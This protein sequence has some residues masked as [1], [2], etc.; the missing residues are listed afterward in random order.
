MAANYG[1]AQ[2]AES[3]RDFIHKLKLCLK[4]LRESVV[5]LELVERMELGDAGAARRS[6]EEADSLAAVLYTSIRTA[7]RNQK[8]K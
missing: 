6:L 1:E 8:P 4:E 5:W 2:S 3:R 7:E